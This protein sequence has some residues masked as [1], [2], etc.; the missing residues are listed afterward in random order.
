MSIK[1]YQFPISHYCEKV[2]WAMDYKGVHYDTVNLLPGRHIKT[3]RH[4]ADQSSVPVIDHDGQCVQGS[5]SII[6]HLDEAFTENSLTPLD[7]D[8]RSEAEAWEHRL[9]ERAGAAVRC[10]CYH[11]LLKKPDL[12]IPLLAARKPLFYQWI[13]KAG[14]RKL[15]A[16]MR[17]WMQI[18]DRTAAAALV[19]IENILAAL[20]A[21]YQK[22]DY[23]VGDQFS[24]AD[25]TAASLFSPLFMPARYP[26]PWPDQKQ[27]P[28]EM[29]WWLSRHQE[30]LQPVQ[31]LYERHR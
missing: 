21:V 26:V 15:E 8:Q 31:A 5:A 24:R 1:L 25:L 11:H 10:Y 22:S 30:L 9:D 23:L 20:N 13:M 12:V 16:T 14:F 18:N 7:P 29:Q 27:L 6:S 3:I 17:H 2:R 19:T 28:A 4:L